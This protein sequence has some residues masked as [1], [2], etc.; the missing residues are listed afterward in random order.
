[1]LYKCLSYPAVWIRLDV[2]VMEFA[3][4]WGSHQSIKP[5]LGNTVIFIDAPIAEL[6]CQ[7]LCLRIIIHS[8]QIA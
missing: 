2:P 4:G 7:H 8:T 6:D 1:M 3:F 5:A